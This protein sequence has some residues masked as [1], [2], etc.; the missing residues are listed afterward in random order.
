MHR[1]ISSYT[2]YNF[3]YL[4]NVIMFSLLFSFFSACYSEV[5]FPTPWRYVSNS[6]QYSWPYIHMKMWWVAFWPSQ[7]W[8][9]CQVALLLAND[10]FFCL[11]KFFHISKSTC[12][13]TQSLQFASLGAFAQCKFFP[14][15]VILKIFQLTT[16]NLQ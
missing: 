6:Y 8:V 5:S 9:Y 11:T 15:P 10:F 1:W 4:I 3:S 16:V 7:E 2:C 14:I 13:D 12:T